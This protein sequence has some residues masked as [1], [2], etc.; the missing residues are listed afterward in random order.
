MR[1]D[2]IQRGWAPASY[3]G[4]TCRGHAIMARGTEHL[5]RGLI[6]SDTNLNLKGQPACERIFR[7]AKAKARRLAGA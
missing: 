7:P 4:A 2:A 1:T 6:D 5:Q 3:M